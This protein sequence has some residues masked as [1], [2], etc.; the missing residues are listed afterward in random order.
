MPFINTDKSDYPQ[1]IHLEILDALTRNDDTI[2]PLIEERN[3]SLMKGYLES[4]YDVE[5]IFDAT[6][7]ER[8][9]VILA[10]LLDIVI[11][12]VFSIHNPQKLSQVR[13]DRYERAMKWL[14]SV[15]KGE[16]AI[17][18]APLVEEAPAG[19]FMAR[20]NPRR[21]NHL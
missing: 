3:I 12:D 1:S 20:S 17:S 21:E 14:K 2:L 6:G 9:R 13:K 10:V 15:R 19:E 8:N 4:R 18:G 16:I 11:Y 7:D 5:A